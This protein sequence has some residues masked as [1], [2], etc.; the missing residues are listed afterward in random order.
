MERMNLGIQSKAH[1]GGP[2]G[3]EGSASTSS[4]S[5]PPASVNEL[6]DSRDS[7]AASGT[8]STEVPDKISN[9][10]TDL[11]SPADFLNPEDPGSGFDSACASPVADPVDLSTLDGIS[12]DFPLNCSSSEIAP[13]SV[14]STPL[15]PVASGTSDTSNNLL[16]PKGVQGQGET[17][18]PLQAKGIIQKTPPHVL[19]VGTG[20]IK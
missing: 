7:T 14:A 18:Q 1:E 17:P 13:G 4:L 15:A 2:A 20:L 8:S 16:P 5:N 11:L 12:L 10:L 6:K 9:S 19:H 3:R